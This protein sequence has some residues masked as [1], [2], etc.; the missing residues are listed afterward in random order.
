MKRCVLAALA[1]VALAAPAG[2]LASGVVLKVQP[3]RHMIAVARTPT[4]VQLVHTNAARRLHVGQRVDLHA[5]TLRDGTL[6]ASRVEIRGHAE[7]VRFRAQVVSVTP[8]R[9]VVSAGG[10]VIVL[11]GHSPAALAPG[12]TVDVIAV[13]GDDEDLHERQLTVFSPTSPGGVVEGRL[14][15]GT[16]SITVTSER[17]SLVIGVPAGFDLT[18]FV[19][20]EEVHATFAQ[21]PNGALSLVKLSGGEDDDVGDHDRGHDDGHHGGGQDGGHGHGGG[22]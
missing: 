18:G 13:V 11:D 6:A 10:A 3:A 2:A 12:S 21:L 5:R 1:V 14:T 4:S 7:S 9:L 15:I 19:Q 16:G 22:H 20:G 8:D 17:Q